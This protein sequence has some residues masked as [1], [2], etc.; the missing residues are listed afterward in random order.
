MLVAFHPVQYGLFV[1]VLLLGVFLVLAAA[2]EAAG[3]RESGALETLFYG[4]VSESIYL[5]SILAAL[6]AAML[7]SGINLMG[8]LVAGLVFIGYEVPSSLFPVLPLAVFCFCGLSA[9]G[10]FVSVLFRQVRIAVMVVT[11]LLVFSLAASAG[12]L[13]FSQNDVSG[14]FALIFLRRA[15]SAA[16]GILS[17]VFPLGLF[18]DDLFRFMEYGRIPPLHILWYVVYGAALFLSAVKILGRL[19]VLMR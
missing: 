10:L 18:I 13:W 8:S 11:I 14:S 17:F 5:L 12:N 15:V 2:A 19:G 1:S 6:S 16:N 7:V 3:D 9:A 4:P